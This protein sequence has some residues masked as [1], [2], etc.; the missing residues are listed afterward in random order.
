VIKGVEMP[1]RK[2]TEKKKAEKERLRKIQ[3]TDRKRKSFKRRGGSRLTCPKCGQ[4][5]WHRLGPN[6]WFCMNCLNERRDY[7]KRC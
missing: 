5:Y 4:K 1:K 7:L 2:I 6:F 3:M